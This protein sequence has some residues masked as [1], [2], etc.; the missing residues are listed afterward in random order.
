MAKKTLLEESVV[1]KMMK[2]ANL[3][4]LSESFLNNEGFEEEDTLEQ[5]LAQQSGDEDDEHQ[6]N[7]KSQG[8]DAPDHKMKDQPVTST[9][10]DNGK[11]LAEN[12]NEMEDEFEDEEEMPVDM[13]PPS[14]MPMDDAPKG[15]P[16]MED[17]D[18]GDLEGLVRAIADAISAQ[19]GVDVT[20]AGHAEPDDDEM[21]MDAMAGDM[22]GDDVPEVDAAPPADN[23]A[24]G[25]DMVDD[26]EDEMDLSEVKTEALQA[27]LDARR[28]QKET[29]FEEQ[30]AVVEAI[31]RKVA[32]RL[33]G[34]K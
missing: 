23:G 20:V 15:E 27:E 22:D 30:A 5:Q 18:T 13:A 12:M 4:N 3:G 32:K 2:F 33:A 21:G 26:D 14:D 19:T 8:T 17:N 28:Q 25:P 24:P 31:A 34:K 16:G 10:I 11:S 6:G 7:A 1:R 9:A 29:E